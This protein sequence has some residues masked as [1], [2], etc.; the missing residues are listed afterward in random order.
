MKCLKLSRARENEKMLSRRRELPGE[1]QIFATGW[2][3][4]VFEGIVHDEAQSESDEESESCHTARIVEWKK[5]S[6]VK[7]SSGFITLFSR[8]KTSEIISRTFPKFQC[9]VRPWDRDY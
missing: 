4:K 9:R 1:T 3:Q 7:S 6:A 2:Y 5:P 8:R